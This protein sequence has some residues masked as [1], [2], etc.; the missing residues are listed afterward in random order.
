VDLYLVS[1][2]VNTPE[3]VWDYSEVISGVEFDDKDILAIVQRKVDMLAMQAYW[4]TLD[5]TR[6]A[7][8]L[9]F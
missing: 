1:C 4:E 2:Q 6:S 7:R 9:E 8:K 3:G 5:I